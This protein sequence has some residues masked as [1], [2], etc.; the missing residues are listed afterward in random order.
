MRATFRRHFDPAIIE[1][2]EDAKLIRH[3][4]VIA[5]I[6]AAESVVGHDCGEIVAVLGSLPQ[7]KLRSSALFAVVPWRQNCQASH[8][9]SGHWMI[10]Q[11]DS[12]VRFCGSCDLP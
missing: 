7:S 3:G 2:V 4:V 12:R 8:R 5:R 11:A 10:R 1:P 6:L 9:R